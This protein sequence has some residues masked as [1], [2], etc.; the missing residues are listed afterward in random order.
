[1][2]LIRENADNVIHRVSGHPGFPATYLGLASATKYA[3]LHTTNHTNYSAK[4]LQMP[5]FERIAFK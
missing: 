1:M 3:F 4:L 2:G 5:L